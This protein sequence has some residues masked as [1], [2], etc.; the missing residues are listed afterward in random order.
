MPELG[1]QVLK[2]FLTFFTAQNDTQAIGAGDFTPTNE[3]VLQGRG[4]E[5]GE[6]A[7]FAEEIVHALGARQLLLNALKRGIGVDDC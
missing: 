2:Y 4:E 5:P 6:D 1:C 3:H 7:I